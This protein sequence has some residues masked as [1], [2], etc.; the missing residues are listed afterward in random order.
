VKSVY[1]ILKGNILAKFR[2]TCHILSESDATKRTLVSDEICMRLLM[3][4][5]STHK[6]LLLAGQNANLKLATN[7]LHIFSFIHFVS[8]LAGVGYFIR[9]LK[10][11]KLNDSFPSQSLILGHPPLDVLSASLKAWMVT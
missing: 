9:K 8:Q 4:Y 7:Y 2:C 1:I 5:D 11:T 10:G 6:T 3:F